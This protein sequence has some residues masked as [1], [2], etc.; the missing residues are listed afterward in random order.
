[1]IEKRKIFSSID[2]RGEFKKVYDSIDLFQLNTVKE[3][4]ISKSSKNTLRGMHFQTKP[5]ELNKIVVCLKG[6][7]LDVIVN[8]DK[9]SKEFGKCI[10]TELIENDSIF[11]SKNYA[12][13][14]YCYE[15]S[16]L[17]Y[18]TDNIYSKE[19]ESGVLWNSLDFNWPIK[20][21]II[22]KRD[23]LLNKINEL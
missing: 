9:Q 19:Y 14:F 16:T 10:F 1:M 7:V 2:N 8:I 23:K 17:L 13:G 11:V 3:I 5:Y 22:S 6:R 21:P 18:I 12:H 15:D 20:N 4:F